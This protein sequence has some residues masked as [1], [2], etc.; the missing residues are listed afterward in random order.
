M[1]AAI[2]YYDKK[3]GDDIRAAFVHLIR[4]VGQIAYA[5]ETSNNPVASAK[6]TEASALL[7]FIGTKYQIDIDANIVEMYSKKLAS[8]AKAKKE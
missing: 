3:Y 6:I 5:L 2:E 7:R 8:L 4:E 1:S